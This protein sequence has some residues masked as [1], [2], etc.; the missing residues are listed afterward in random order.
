M[1]AADP[2]RL[3]IARTGCLL[4]EA[5]QLTARYFDGDEFWIAACASCAVPMVVWRN[6]GIAPTAAT[7]KRMLEKLHDVAGEVFDGGGYRIDRQRRSIPGH[8]HA[9]ARPSSD[10]QAPSNVARPESE[11]G[12]AC[13]LCE[14]APSM[15]QVLDHNDFWVGNC[16]VCGRGLAV[17]WHAHAVTPP[18]GQVQRMLDLLHQMGDRLFGKGWYRID[19]RRGEFPGHWHA[20]LRASYTMRPS[21]RAF[22]WVTDQLGVGG[23]RSPQ[24]GD[25]IVASGVTHVIDLRDQ[26]DTEAAQRSASE[27]GIGY[28]SLPLPD[29]QRPRPLSWWAAGLEVAEQILPKK[30]SRL[31]VVCA[32]GE[33]RAPSMAYLILRAAGKAPTE[34]VKMIKAARPQVTIRYAVDGERFFRYWTGDVLPTGVPAEPVLG[35]R[36]FGDLRVWAREGPCELWPAIGPPPNARSAMERLLIKMFQEDRKPHVW[37][38]RTKSTTCSRHPD[39]RCVCDWGLYAC[40]TLEDLVG[41]MTA[42]DPVEQEGRSP[43]VALV[44]SADH[45]PA[46]WVAWERS[47]TWRTPTMVLERLLVPE[48]TNKNVA[49]TVSAWFGVP[50]DR[51]LPY[52]TSVPIPRFVDNKRRGCRRS[53]RRSCATHR[54]GVRRSRSQPTA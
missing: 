20:H 2:N 21:P 9:H 29:D 12:A 42:E 1:V 54:G 39:C 16:G 32:A 25:D 28:T 38:K 45:A 53:R 18:A 37:T 15:P 10:Q 48:R 36:A 5:A 33:N 31:L 40:R 35:W 6:H 8:W 50:V 11:T 44:R 51:M 26:V 43:V 14:V 41:Y 24:F 47:L 7:V 52:A 49:A 19:R 17:V 3:A 13:R 27:K 34:A 46:W 22:D 23:W 30:D 4:C